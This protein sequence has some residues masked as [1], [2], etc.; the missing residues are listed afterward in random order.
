MTNDTIE[1]QS[2]G[3]LSQERKGK[4]IVLDRD[5]LKATKD[6]KKKEKEYQKKMFDVYVDIETNRLA[7]ESQQV[8]LAESLQI[9]CKNQFL[10]ELKKIICDDEAKTLGYQMQS[11]ATMCT[12][13]QR[14]LKEEWEAAAEYIKAMDSHLDNIEE[15]ELEACSHLRLEQKVTVAVPKP[16]DDNDDKVEYSPDF[17][18]KGKDLKAKDKQDKD[19]E[20]KGGEVLAFESD[21]K[22]PSVPATEEES[23]TPGVDD[24]G[25]R[26]GGAAGIHMQVYKLDM[27]NIGD[28]YQNESKL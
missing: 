13:S 9:Y 20:D 5:E 14:E 1:V 8:D 11:A 2:T 26:S 24:T 21:D 28:T 3:N 15:Q 7:K 19:Q 10:R 17:D 27:K 16:C 4:S 12:Q 18:D 23:S 25:E 22:G 6:F